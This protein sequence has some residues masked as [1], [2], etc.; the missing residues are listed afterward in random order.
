MIKNI[1]YIFCTICMASVVSLAACNKVGDPV[2][3]ATPATDTVLYTQTTADFPNP[4]RG[5]YRVAE[6]YAN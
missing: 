5:F 6:T 3:Y 2:T 1:S 4:E